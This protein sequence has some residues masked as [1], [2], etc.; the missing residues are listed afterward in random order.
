MALK[1]AG[2]NKR[3][4]LTDIKGRFHVSITIYFDSMTPLSGGPCIHNNEIIWGYWICDYKLIEK[5]KKIMTKIKSLGLPDAGFDTDGMA[6]Y[7][8]E[9]SGSN[10]YFIVYDNKSYK[11]YQFIIPNSNE[12]FYLEKCY[13]KKFDIE[14]I[15][16][17]KIILNI[18]HINRNFLNDKT[19]VFDEIK[20]TVFD[21]IK[22]I[23]I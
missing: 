21:D 19:N 23:V 16:I 10:E 3:Y 15:E 8:Y 9:I 6:M 13:T 12:K 1:L 7:S 5:Y 17:I 14:T 20:T 11:Y 2:S 22:T 4:D 18:F